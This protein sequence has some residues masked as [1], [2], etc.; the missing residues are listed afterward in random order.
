MTVIQWPTG[1]RVAI[2]IAKC[3]AL[4]TIRRFNYCLGCTGTTCKCCGGT[5]KHQAK[6]DW[7]EQFKDYSVPTV[8]MLQECPK[9]HPY[10]E[11][12]TRWTTNMHGKKV[13]KCK[14]CDREASRVRY[15]KNKTAA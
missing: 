13:R 2:S 10:N 8:T 9:G 15:H 5:G 4:E 1:A 14:E 11:D 3:G 12:N 6:A 7:E